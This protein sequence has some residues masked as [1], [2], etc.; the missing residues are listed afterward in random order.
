MNLFVAL[1]YLVALDDHKHFG[2]AALACHVTQPALSNALRAL[3]AHY[4]C[5]IVRRGRSFEGFSAEG[6]RVLQSARRMLREQEL[7]DQD[8]K[9]RAGAPQGHLLVGAVPTA[10]P[11]AA[12]FVAQLQQRHP[13]ILPTLRSLSSV[14]LE[15]GLDQ[16]ALD[17][18]LGYT[19]RTAETRVP[20]RL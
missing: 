2:R 7:L 6:E 18:G 19:E 5:A 20:L 1:R 10:L 17:L 12:R 3:E 14:E 4:G 16:L 9:S 15:T 11:I 8:L 13:G